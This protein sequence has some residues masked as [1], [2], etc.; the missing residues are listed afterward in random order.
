MYL[1]Y[2]MSTRTRSTCKYPS[3]RCLLCLSVCLLSVCLLSVCLLSACLLS[4]CLSVVCLSVLQSVILFV[5]SV[6]VSFCMFLLVCQ[7]SVCMP[8][9]RKRFFVYLLVC[10]NIS[11]HVCN[12]SLFVS[13]SECFGSCL[14]AL[15]HLC[16]GSLSVSLYVLIHVLNGSVSVSLC[17]CFG[18]CV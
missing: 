3:L 16:N 9:C 5:G 7:C 10:L 14:N 12:G 4:A 11:V 1:D 18:S 17:E 2:T 8:V 6:S 15:V 13:L